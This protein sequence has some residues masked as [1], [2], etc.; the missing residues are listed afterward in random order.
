MP[1]TTLTQRWHTIEGVKLPVA[2]LVAVVPGGL[3][4]RC[5]TPVEAWL[6]G[7]TQIQPTL[8]R[9]QRQI[10]IPAPLIATVVERMPEGLRA[11]VQEQRPEW[12]ALDKAEKARQA[13]RE[14]LW[15]AEQSGCFEPAQVKGGLTLDLDERLDPFQKV[16]VEWLSRAAGL[17]ILGDDMGLGKT[18]QTL[19]YL[20]RTPEAQ[21]T[22]IVC[23]T[24]VTVNWQREAAVW[25]P[26]LTC[27][28]APTKRKAEKAIGELTSRSAL[29]LSWGMVRLVLDKLLDAGFDTIVCDEAHNMKEPT[30]QRTQ[31][32]LALGYGAERRIAMTGTSVRNRPRELWTLLHFVD[33][34]RF[35]VFEVFGERYCGARWVRIGQG[36]EV[37]TYDGKTRQAELNALTR[38]YLVRR[39]KRQVLTQ[40]PPKRWQRV[41][42]V[43][44][45][46]FTK[47][48]RAVLEELQKYR[49]ADLG[50]ALGMLQGLRQ[51]IGLEKVD[52]AIEQ[53]ES[54]LAAD[55]PVVLFLYHASVRQEIEAALARRG[56]RFGTIVGGVSATKRQH[57]VDAFQNGDIDVLIGSEACKEGITLTRSRITL[58][59][60]YW[61]TPGDQAQA[62][63][64]VARRGQTRATLHV[65]LH[66]TGS[67][68]DHVAT[69]LAHK[70]K[71]IDKLMDRT[72]IER[73]V[74]A[75]IL[76]VA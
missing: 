57:I 65:Y 49:G 25:A 43:A 4:L 2:A 17:A 6:V 5:P 55:E 30:S 18:V 40:L 21:R 67:L 58:H 19:A 54:M 32:I 38:A 15:L 10:F 14:P 34:M 26:S 46:R 50:K 48:Y 31:A 70:R 20:E 63:D 36:R 47:A 35:A 64:R 27:L 23:P 1:L 68:D 59:V 29:I 76:E 41:D 75:S 51:Q 62:E 45:P 60:E 39:D 66:L 44:P 42:L 13:K 33:P 11:L 8:E 24:S 22:L 52:A 56:I 73:S 69:L 7:L 37:R 28:V 12:L 72:S 9:R 61:W 16:G 71:T 3:V 53:V 74:L